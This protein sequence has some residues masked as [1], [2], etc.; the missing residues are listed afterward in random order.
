MKKLIIGILI[1]V[2]A[3]VISKIIFFHFFIALIDLWAF[4]SVS[5]MATIYVCILHGFKGS[6]N[7]FKTPLGNNASDGELQ[8]ALKFFNNLSEAYL[9]FSGFV[10]SI[11]IVDMFIK[12]NEKM[13]LGPRL[14][15]AIISILYVALMHLLIIIPY[16]GIIKNQCS[17]L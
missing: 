3:F 11:S 5:I 17:V 15:M 16:K 7:S 2:L 1:V 4:I 10:V 9:Y 6:I 8:L 13:K 14:A 12:F